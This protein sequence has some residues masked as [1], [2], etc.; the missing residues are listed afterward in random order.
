MKQDNNLSQGKNYGTQG[1]NLTTGYT[2]EQQSEPTYPYLRAVLKRAGLG[3]LIGIAVMDLITAL[4]GSGIPASDQLID[5]VGSIRAARL[6]QMLLSALYGALCM[7]STILYDLERL[8]LALVSL[9]HCVIC[10]LPFIPISRFLGWYN[11]RTEALIMAGIQLMAYVIVWLIM[12]LQY[13][14]ETRRLNEIR[15]NNRL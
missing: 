2:N 12:Y 8:P 14:K 13:R 6:M 11:G 1:D 7:G 4:T 15:K 10:I 3:A 9:S 5:T